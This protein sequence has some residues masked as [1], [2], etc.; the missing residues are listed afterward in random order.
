[1]R[2]GQISVND[3]DGRQSRERQDAG[4]ARN[5]WVIN[6]LM[7]VSSSMFMTTRYTFLCYSLGL[8]PDL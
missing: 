4:A 7:G 2:Q 8:C 3:F 1:M 6:Q 5:L